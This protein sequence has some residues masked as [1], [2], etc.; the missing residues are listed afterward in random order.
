MRD[1]E[2]KSRSMSY[3]IGNTP[4]DQRS[5]VLRDMREKFNI[6]EVIIYDKQLNIL[7]LS[8]ANDA[9]IPV[10][11]KYEDVERSANDF[12]G[13]IE[14]VNDKIILRAYMPIISNN[15]MSLNNI[16][17]EIKQPIPSE[18]ANL[19]ISVESVYEDYQRLAY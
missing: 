16:F 14:E 17:L 6:E 1:V 4:I 11:P 15:D 2:L 7:A 12:Y 9:Q 13:V 8:S 18:I 5:S 19:A 3:T 10:I